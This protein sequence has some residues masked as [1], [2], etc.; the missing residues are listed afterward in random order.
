MV[1]K[2]SKDPLFGNNQSGQKSFVQFRYFSCC[3]CNDMEAAN[4]A[5]E[6]VHRELQRG[7]PAPCGEQISKEALIR[8]ASSK[9]FAAT[10]EAST[11]N[12]NT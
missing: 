1:E 5:A 8:S 12:Y 4:A 7:V 2:K 9:A 3:C 11:G 10:T 6:A